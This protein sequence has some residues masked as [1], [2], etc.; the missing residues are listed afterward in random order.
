MSERQLK[1]LE[2][3]I[4]LKIKRLFAAVQV[5]MNEMTGAEIMGL[6]LPIETRLEVIRDELVKPNVLR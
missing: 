1:L 5:T 6:M 2:E 4:D 3:F